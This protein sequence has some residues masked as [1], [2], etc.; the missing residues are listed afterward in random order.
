MEHILY[1]LAKKD[2]VLLKKLLPKEYTFSK[3]YREVHDALRQRN[4]EK[5]FTIFS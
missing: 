2:H 3:I 5:V 1:H 4:R